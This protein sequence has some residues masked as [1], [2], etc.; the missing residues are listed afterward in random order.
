MS[1]ATSNF[2]IP[3]ATFFVEL[4]AFLIVLAVIGKYAL[5]YLKTQLDE[6]VGKIRGELE[7][8]DEAKADAEAADDERRS[9]L[10]GARQQ[11]REIVAQA[12][13]TAE[14]LTT[15]GQ[16]RGQE[17]YQRLL[18][19]AEA[20][21]ALARQRA[22]DEAAARLGELVMDVVERVIG[23]EVDAEAHRAL[24]DEAVEAL[25]TDSDAGGSAATGAGTRA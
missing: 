2:L 6:R 12:A 16:I 20:D 8:A 15:D 17:E 22:V 21:V 24:I 3:N 7:A 14:Q 10:E 19:S 4:V 11:A 1:I 25:R 13:R 9:T 5:P 18:E 23:R